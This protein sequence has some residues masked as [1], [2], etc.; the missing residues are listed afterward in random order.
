MPLT[1]DQSKPKQNISNNLKKE[2]HCMIPRSIKEKEQ[3]IA[4]F[5]YTLGNLTTY[6]GWTCS[7]DVQFFLNCVS[8][9]LG[10]LSSPTEQAPESGLKFERGKLC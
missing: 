7:M 6:Q 8:N 9:T 10:D 4:Q 2:E 3:M 5:S 1:T